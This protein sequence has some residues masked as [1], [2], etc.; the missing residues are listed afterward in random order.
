MRLCYGK[1]PGAKLCKVMSLWRWHGRNEN[2]SQ[3]NPSNEPTMEEILASIRKIISE[4]QPEPAQTRAPE[5]E[6]VPP[7][8][9]E[10][11]ALQDVH[12]MVAAPAEISLGMNHL[13][14]R[15]D[16]PLPV[17]DFGD[18]MPFAPMAEPPETY[19]E[20]ASMNDDLISASTRDALDRAFER[21]EDAPAPVAAPIRS[22]ADSGNGIDAL[23]ARAIQDAFEPTLQGWVD[24]H[25]NEIVSRLSPLI[26]EWMDE[27]LPSLIES[28]VQKEIA[29][30]VRSRK[31]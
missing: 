15:F 22:I 8:V 29:R 24:D 23:F 25:R 13:S 14:D 9:E 31:R 6:V 17:Q 3:A 28:A 19:A 7:M 18:D 20:E 10:S 4:D 1:S 2:M 12:D 21:I 5:P 26:R 16:E 11:S 30:A 27:N